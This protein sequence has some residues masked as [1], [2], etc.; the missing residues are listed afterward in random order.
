[1]TP[2]EQGHGHVLIISPSA[3]VGLGCPSWELQLWV[4]ECWPGPWQVC[5]WTHAAYG[6]LLAANALHPL[7]LPV[8]DD[9]MKSRV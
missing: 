2:W 3:A 7:V 1:M 9:R 8:S 4:Q 5:S 6:R